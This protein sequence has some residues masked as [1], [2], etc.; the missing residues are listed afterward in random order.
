MSMVLIYIC[1]KELPVWM[2]NT[3]YFIAPSSFASSTPWLYVVGDRF[4]SVKSADI[5]S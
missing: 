5:V 1:V 3:R 4:A 2:R